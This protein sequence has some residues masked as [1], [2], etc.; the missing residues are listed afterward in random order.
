M[1][2][3]IVMIH[4]WLDSKL[5][6]LRENTSLQERLLDYETNG[7]IACKKCGKVRMR[8]ILYTVNLFKTKLH[9]TILGSKQCRFVNNFCLHHSHGVPW[10]F[11]KASNAPVSISRTL[12]WNTVIKTKRTTNGASCPY[13]SLRLTTRNTQIS[14]RGTRT[15]MRTKRAA[16]KDV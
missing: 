1:M 2:L 7:V 11:I 12:W 13:A 3:R 5:F 14:S 8:F 4:L 9:R 16:Q 6:I 10:C 15:V